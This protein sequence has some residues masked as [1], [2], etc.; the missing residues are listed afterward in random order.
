MSYAHPTLGTTSLVWTDPEITSP[1]K[2]NSSYALCDNI[3]HTITVTGTNGV[4]ELM[5][6]NKNA[7]NV[8]DTVYEII[9]AVYVG[10]VPSKK[11]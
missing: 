2:M 5:V 9:G 11:H 8:T 7:T 6:N 1:L 3:Y 4:V 10:G